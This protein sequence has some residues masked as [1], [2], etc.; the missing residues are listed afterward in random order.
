MY[1]NI[2]HAILCIKIH[3]PRIFKL[4]F[5]HTISEMDRY[6]HGITFLVTFSTLLHTILYIKIHEVEN[7][8]VCE[9]VNILE[10]YMTSR[11]RFIRR[12]HHTFA[13]VFV[14]S[15]EQKYG[16]PPMQ[17][18]CSLG[19]KKEECALSKSIYKPIS[20]RVR[21]HVVWNPYK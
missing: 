10:Y 7:F 2:L 3:D 21:A 17:K 5:T 1:V 11:G 9:R 16:V 8:C 18:L 19:I 12:R 15:S 4:R 20:G 13:T 6:S 14:L